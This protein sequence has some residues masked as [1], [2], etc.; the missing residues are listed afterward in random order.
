MYS[1]DFNAKYLTVGSLNGIPFDHILT[2]KTDQVIEYLKIEGAIKVNEP[3][4][5]MRFYTNGVNEKNLIDL[6]IQRENSVLVHDKNVTILT[7]MI[8]IQEAKILGSMTCKGYINSKRIEDIVLLN[9]SPVFDSKMNFRSL[10][11]QSI[12]SDY[13][14]SG[15]D[16]KNWL[17]TR[18][19]KRSNEVQVITNQWSVKQ[20]KFN[21]DCNGNGLINGRSINQIQKNLKEN[22]NQVQAFLSNYTGQYTQLCRNLQSQVENYGH[23]SVHILKY[24][25]LDFKIVEDRDIYSFYDFSTKDGNYLIVNFGCNSKVYLWMKSQQKYQ[26]TSFTE[27]G[28]IYDYASFRYEN[29]D[30]FVITNSKVP[31]DAP[32][33]FNGLNSWKLDNRKLVHI[34]A[35]KTDGAVNKIFSHATHTRLFYALDSTDKVMSFD[36]FGTKLEEWK[37]PSESLSYSFLPHGI[38]P[39]LNLYNGRRIFS[40]ESKRRTKRF[41]YE[42]IDARKALRNQTSARKFILNPPDYSMPTIKPITLQSVKEDNFLS[43]IR[44]AGEIIKSSLSKG[45]PVAGEKNDKKFQMNLPKF[46]M[47]QNKEQNVTTETRE[48][49]TEKSKDGDVNKKDPLKLLFTIKNPNFPNIKDFGEKDAEKPKDFNIKKVGSS[50]FDS[51][52]NPFNI[53]P[54]T[55]SRAEIE[56]PAREENESI[57]TIQPSENATTP[58]SLM[59]VETP[60]ERQA[61]TTVVQT[62]GVRELENSF[63]PEHG[64]I[65]VIHVGPADQKK[66]LFAVSRKRSSIVVSG[67][68]KG[69]DFIEVRNIFKQFSNF[70]N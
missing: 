1:G 23:S 39:D 44:N 42:D 38:L 16:F 18:I 7:P 13:L 5:V 6:M 27:T 30:F 37:L 32:C 50:I 9:S 57:T 67:G 66:Q 34:T 43:K 40:L 54:P 26:E 33:N 45:L 62:F 2:L 68:D 64:E 15:I 8:F 49:N 56:E 41:W 14:I 19:W 60:Q 69:N 55:T 35:V 53:K 3:L 36:A 58:D 59:A 4:N 11:V 48:E 10:E 31:S 47:R 65:I 12:N 63:I 61:E 17:K 52:V 24:L 25:E 29:G 21:A 22:V 51:M 28:I 46:A 20:A 70:N